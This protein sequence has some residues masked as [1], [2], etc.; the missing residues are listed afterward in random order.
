M[1]PK[2]RTLLILIAI[3]VPLD[4]LTKYLVV[5]HVPYGGYAVPFQALEGFFHITHSRNA[6]AALGL[7]QNVHVYFFVA[8][9]GVALILIG[10]FFRRIDAADRLSAV[11]LRLIVAR[12]LGHML[13]RVGP[14]A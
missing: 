2:F 5:S 1:S 12:A 4:Q 9:T 13:H 6:G 3:V 11:S 8:L 14:R 7:A 10:S